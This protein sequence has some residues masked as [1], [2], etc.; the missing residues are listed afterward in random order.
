MRIHA[1]KMLG[2]LILF[3]MVVFVWNDLTPIVVYQKENASL[4]I[5]AEFVV[6]RQIPFVGSYRAA[7]RVVNAAGKTVLEKPLP[8]SLDLPADATDGFSITS[9]SREEIRVRSIWTQS[10]EPL[11][12]SINSDAGK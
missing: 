1:G 2:A 3:S 7:L 10:G 12:F 4:G 11:F 8:G 6:R 9:M 5:V